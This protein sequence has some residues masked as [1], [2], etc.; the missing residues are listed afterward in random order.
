MITKKTR[1]ACERSPVPAIVPSSGPVRTKA[2]KSRQ[3]IRDRN[4]AGAWEDGGPASLSHLGPPRGFRQP[5]RTGGAP[6]LGETM[7]AG[8]SDRRAVKIRRRGRHASPSQVE[9]VAQQAGKAAPVVAIAGALVAVPSAQALAASAGRRHGQ[10]G[11]LAPARAQGAGTAH[12]ATADAR[13]VRDTHRHG[14]R[15]Q[16]PPRHAAADA[17]RTTGCTAAIRCRGFPSG[18]TTTPATGSTSTTRTKRRS[19]T[20]T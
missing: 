9:K 7:T 8:R 6:T 5:R 2:L 13:L 19:R 20:R 18:S 11:H 1:F 15:R 3:V 14:R 10:Q 16:A 12:T 17:P 4:R